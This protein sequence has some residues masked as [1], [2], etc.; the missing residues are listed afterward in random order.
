VMN[1][2][3]YLNTQIHVYVWYICIGIGRIELRHVLKRARA[4]TCYSCF[5]LN[6]FSL[7]SYFLSD[8]SWRIFENLLWARAIVRCCCH[9]IRAKHN[10]AESLSHIVF[11]SLRSD[12][13]PIKWSALLRA[14]VAATPVATN[15]RKKK[16][17]TKQSKAK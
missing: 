8:F 16:Q 6:L 2:T 12:S 11:R 1:E 14:Q 10:L 5:F 13:A 7:A 4:V 17:K 15:T 3:N 9:F